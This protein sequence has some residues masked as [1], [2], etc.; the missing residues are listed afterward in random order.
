MKF[1]SHRG[2]IHGR[3]IE[4]ENSPS[5]IEE[6]LGLGFEVEIDVWC[7]NGM[8]LLGHDQPEYQVSIDF[9]RKEEIWCHVKNVEALSIFTNDPKIHFFWHQKDDYTI[10]SHNIIWVYPGKQLPSGSVCVMP[11][12]TNY[13]C[14]ELISCFGICSDNIFDFRERFK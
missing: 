8:F 2:N 12:L 5:K 9:L 10:T 7:V 14:K 1:I 6:C 13:S 3:E 11:E 4:S